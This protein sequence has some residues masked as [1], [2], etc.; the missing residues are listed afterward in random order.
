MLRKAKQSLDINEDEWSYYLDA[1]DLEL[2]INKKKNTKKACNMFLELLNTKVDKDLCDLVNRTLDQSN[3]SKCEDL[4]E[5]DPLSL[6]WVKTGEKNLKKRFECDGSTEWWVSR[7]Q[8]LFEDKNGLFL[9]LIKYPD[10]EKYPDTPELKD[11]LSKKISHFE[12]YYLDVKIDYKSDYY[13]DLGEFIEDNLFGG[14]MVTLPTYTCF[15]KNAGDLED[16]DTVRVMVLS[17]KMIKVKTDKYSDLNIYALPKGNTL[18]YRMHYNA[19][20][21]ILLIFFHMSKEDCLKY[22]NVMLNPKEIYAICN[23]FDSDILKAPYTNTYNQE[24]K[25]IVKHK[26]LSGNWLANMIDY[27][28][29]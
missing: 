26:D 2:G 17:D 4:K 15:T 10:M 6:S 11:K 19:D 23:E 25:D 7:L 13:S 22:S 3:N 5:K 16:K 27:F 29:H 8:D 12:K 28:N 24:W 18:L 9:P 1:C 20:G 21:K 14:T